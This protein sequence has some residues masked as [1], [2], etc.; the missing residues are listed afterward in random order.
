MY[1]QLACSAYSDIIDNDLQIFL[2]EILN[3]RLAIR[4]SKTCQSHLC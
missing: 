3:R 1:K 4:R 2:S